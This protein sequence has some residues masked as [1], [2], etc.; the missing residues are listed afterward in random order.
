MHYRYMNL[1]RYH[2]DMSPTNLF[3][4]EDIFFNETLEPAE[5]A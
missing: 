4:P 1:N 3:A 2:I 5:G